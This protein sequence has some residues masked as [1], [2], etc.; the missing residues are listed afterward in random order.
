MDLRQLRY[1]VTLAEQRH[2][3][4]ASELLNIAQPPLSQQMKALEADLGVELFDRSTRPI[5]LTPAGQTLLREAR[6]ILSQVARAEATTRRAGVGDGG[7]LV[8]GV[9]GTAALEFAAPALRAFGRRRPNVQLALREM[10]SPAQLVALA[11]GDIHLGFLRPPVPDDQFAIKLVHTD[12]FV[13]ALPADHP[14][15]RQDAIRLAELNGAPLVIFESKEAPAFRD[16]ILHV[17]RSAGFVP[18]MIQDAQQIMTM[19]CLVGSGMGIALVPRSARRLQI[20]GVVFRPLID[21]SPDV[22]LYAAWVP[23]DGASL[24]QDLLDLIDE[25]ASETRVRPDLNIIETRK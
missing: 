3:G 16:L 18:S 1:F 22:E 9:T 4:R 2:F 5:G 10:S 13:V 17:C 21:T 8:I 11:A 6:L 7:R 12:P 23:N 25:D 19:L 14:R 15:A 24:A 20:E